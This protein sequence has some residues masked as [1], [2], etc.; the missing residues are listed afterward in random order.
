[1]LWIS[2]AMRLCWTFDRLQCG[3]LAA[4]VELCAVKRAWCPTGRKT[5][6]PWT[7]TTHSVHCQEEVRN[8]TRAGGE[9]VLW[10]SRPLLSICKWRMPLASCAV[11]GS[12]LECKLVLV[13]CVFSSRHW[14]VPQVKSSWLTVAVTWA[15][16][17]KGKS[18]KMT[19]WTVSHQH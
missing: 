17:V 7:H 2:I 18:P 16:V 13:P 9:Q 15:A 19:Y 11:V 3:R 6:G 10:L 12:A 1:M 8:P 4:E 14:R 5:P